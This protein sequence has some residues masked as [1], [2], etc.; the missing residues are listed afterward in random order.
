MPD[1]AGYP[2]VDLYEHR[3]TRAAPFVETPVAEVLLIEPAPEASDLE[4][5]S[6]LDALVSR[7]TLSDYRYIGAQPQPAILAIRSR[8]RGA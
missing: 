8:S 1:T 5:C 3:V 6:A 7:G 4:H 2:L